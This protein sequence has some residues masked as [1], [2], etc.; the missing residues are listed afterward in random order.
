MKGSSH[1]LLGLFALGA[2]VAPANSLVGHMPLNFYD[3]HAM[4]ALALAGL[5]AFGGALL[6]DIDSDEST[7]RQGTGTARSSGCMGK[8]ASWVIRLATGGH[9]MATHSLVA[10]AIV[11]GAAWLAVQAF[12]GELVGLAFV[13]GYAS[14]LVGDALTVDGIPALWPLT[15]HRI[16]LLPKLIAIRTGSFFEYA[17]MVAFGIGLVKLW[18]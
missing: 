11:G 5:A 8:L 3:A 16:G 4:V 10:L 9:R 12:G 17:L 14:H 2:Y 18:M 6:P 15:R 1:A 13:L 7:I